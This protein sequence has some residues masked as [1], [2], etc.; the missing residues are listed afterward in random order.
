MTRIPQAIAV[1]A[2]PVAVALLVLAAG[3]QPASALAAVVI[4]TLGTIAA[5]WVFALGVGWMQRPR[6]AGTWEIAIRRTTEADPTPGMTGTPLAPD[7][8]ALPQR[9]APQ[10][11][12]HVIDGGTVYKRGPAPERTPLPV[13]RRQIGDRS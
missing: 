6:G 2:A 7:T 13:P 12:Q 3:G 4:A 1:I 11:L 8:A 5:M 9:P 10:A